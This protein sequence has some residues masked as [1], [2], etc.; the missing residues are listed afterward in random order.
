MGLELD[1]AF[2]TGNYVPRISVQGGKKCEDEAQCGE[3]RR[4]ETTASSSSL[5][6]SV[7]FTP[8]HFLHGSLRPP[9]LA[10]LFA[11]CLEEGVG[12]G[13]IV[14]GEERVKRGGGVIGTCMTVE[15]CELAGEQCKGVGEWNDLLKQTPL[16]SGVEETRWVALSCSEAD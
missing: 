12:D 16:R 9:F 15:D 5:K 2:F 7:A 3:K 13:W 8:T 10:T 14:G 4:A 6:V 11:A 1:T